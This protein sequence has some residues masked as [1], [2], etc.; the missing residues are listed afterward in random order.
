MR[1]T[2]KTLTA[3]IVIATGIAAIPAGA[4]DL[5]VSPGETEKL[6]AKLPSG[7][8]SLRL[9]G[10]IDARDLFALRKL[11]SSVTTLDISGT[12]VAAYTSTAVLLEGRLS[13]P[14]AYIPDFAL[15]GIQVTSLS[16]PS[17]VTDIGEGALAGIPVTSLTLPPSLRHAGDYAFYNCSRLTEIILPA[18]LSKLG[19]A[20]FGRCSS[21][22]TINLADTKIS[23]IPDECFTDCTSL[24]NITMPARIN[25]L[26]REVLRGS[27][28]ET[29]DISGIVSTSPFALCGIPGLKEV[30]LHGSADY[31]PGL[32]MGNSKLTSVNRYPNDVPALF[33][34][35][36]TL[37]DKKNIIKDAESLGAFSIAGMKAVNINL[38]DGLAYVDKDA[39]A[40]IPTLVSIDASALKTQTPDVAPDAF[41]SINP[42]NIQLYV[43]PESVDIWKAHPEWGKM[44]VIP[45]T[46]SVTD[47]NYTE[48]FD[49][50]LRYADGNLTVKATAMMTAIAIYSI[51]GRL[52]SALSPGADT[53]SVR[54]DL[55]VATPV[56]VR[57]DTS[58]HTKILKTIL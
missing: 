51:D 32:L 56:V 22:V 18:S 5:K 30:T 29:L 37:L 52:I 44:Q 40:G 50:T 7:D 48:Q 39:F 42:S 10:T 8:S 12:T 1:H 26:G 41:E 28:I 2:V 13:Y 35:A 19:T 46:N 53:T 15:L 45:N 54:L 31:A 27:G 58:R 49:V 38:G 6:L 9:T 33:V 4:A 20:A 24:K 57:V 21:L 55:P 14:A 47:T 23:D 16:L 11:P 36:C 25:H 3:A 17:G 43:T 34:A